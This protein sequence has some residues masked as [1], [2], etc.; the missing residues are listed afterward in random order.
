MQSLK[1]TAT[2]LPI[3]LVVDDDELVLDG[4]EATFEDDFR[5]LT[6]GSAERARELV[7]EHTIDIVI[8][9]DR[10]PQETGVSFL[11]W[12]AQEQPGAV[13]ILL[14]GFFSE[15]GD[16]RRAI[17]QGRMWHYMR[18]PWEAGSMENIVQRALESR[19]LA[20]SAQAAERRYRRLYDAVPCPLVTADSQGKA[21]TWN[22]SFAQFFG[23]WPQGGLSVAERLPPGVWTSLVEQVLRSED[24]GAQAPVTVEGPG[25]ALS[26]TLRLHQNSAQSFTAALAPAVASMPKPAVQAADLGPSILLL[27]EDQ[28]QRRL[29]SRALGKGGMRTATAEDL[30][31]AVSLLESAPPSMVLAQG[32]IQVLPG[33]QMLLRRFPGRP[34]LLCTP[35]VDQPAIQAL[36]TRGVQLLAM[37]YSL[38]DLLDA[39]KGRLPG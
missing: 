39:V 14:T 17:S 10:L 32:D 21:L 28:G 18:K 7:A 19:Q 2:P 31:Q 1:A 30:D 22:P 3:L 26:F 29:L 8:S 33:L 36:A 11:G 27:A 13:R 6:A 9:D 4:L 34:I 35:D 12:L 16:V 23:D 5:V 38:T 25:G 24:G 37:P 20:L 15:P